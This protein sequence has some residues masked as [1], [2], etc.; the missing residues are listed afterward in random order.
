MA[1]Y[2][3]EYREHSVC[4]IDIEAN[5]EKEALEEFERLAARDEFKDE[6]ARMEVEETSAVA[7]LVENSARNDDVDRDEKM[8]KG[9]TNNA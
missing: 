1:T 6:F 5:S 9:E 4:W 7:S 8:M 2:C 3:V